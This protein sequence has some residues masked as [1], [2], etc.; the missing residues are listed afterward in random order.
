MDL[1]PHQN[2]N[3][4]NTILSGDQPLFLNNIS[5]IY[6]V[7]DDYFY[8]AI[9]DDTNFIRSSQ[10]SYANENTPLE[11]ITFYNGE[12]LYDHYTF[13]LP[14][15]LTPTKLDYFTICYYPL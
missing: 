11:T 13:S 4:S 15:Q 1:Y 5:F 7:S 9:N 2:Y 14:S 10:F 6:V 12:L 8:Y 3:Y